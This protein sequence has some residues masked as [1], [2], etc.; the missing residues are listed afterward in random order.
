MELSW[1]FYDAMVGVGIELLR[2]W[3]VF[4]TEWGRIRYGAENNKI[5]TDNTSKF[6]RKN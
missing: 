6:Y 2:C 4:D 5:T 3:V 1:K